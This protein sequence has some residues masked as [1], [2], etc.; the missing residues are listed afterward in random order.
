MLP[1]EEAQLPTQAVEIAEHAKA[2]W[3]VR[4]KEKLETPHAA[5][6]PE[7][8]RFDP[9]HPDWHCH[10]HTGRWL[11]TSTRADVVAGEQTPRLTARRSLFCKERKT[12]A[13]HTRGSDEKG[14]VVL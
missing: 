3:I 5:F 10:L 9:A 7:E 4:V 13:Q 2:L 8:P 12:G 11:S 1:A 14:D 6:T